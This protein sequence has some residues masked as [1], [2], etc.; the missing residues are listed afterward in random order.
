MRAV[1]RTPWAERRSSMHDE[2]CA[3][4]ARDPMALM[5]FVPLANRIDRVLVEAPCGTGFC[6]LILEMHG[7]SAACFVEVKTDA[8]RAS[9]GD[10]IR[11]LRW[12]A[13]QSR[14]YDRHYLMCVP[15]SPQGRVFDS[16]LSAAGVYQVVYGDVWDI[17]RANPRAYG[18]ASGATKGRV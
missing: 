11:Q 7:R 3:V 14:G 6:D 10:V 4:L 5:H 16:L 18:A 12:Y 15:E 8:E 2:I 13:A 1:E 17:S 9:G